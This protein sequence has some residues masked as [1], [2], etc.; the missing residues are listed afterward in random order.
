MPRLKLV[1]PVSGRVIYD[2][3]TVFPE[4]LDDERDHIVAG[5]GWKLQ[6]PEQAIRELKR[7]GTETCPSCDSIVVTLDDG[8]YTC[9]IC[10]SSW[11]A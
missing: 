4:Q 11:E 3:D 8:A 10:K 7:D 1:D 2:S 6:T 5:Q 9:Q